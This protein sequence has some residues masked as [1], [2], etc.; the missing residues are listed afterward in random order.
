MMQYL[1]SRAGRAIVMRLAQE[2]T[3]CAFDFDGTL[4]PIVEHPAEAAMRAQ[5]RTLLDGL[6]ALYPCVILSGR[7]RADLLG[8]LDGV[9]VAGVI[10]NHG[11]ETEATALRQPRRVE[12]WKATLERELGAVPGVW[13]EDKILSLAVHYR[14]AAQKTEA[15]RRILA[16]VRDLEHV[17]VV[18]GKQ[19]VNLVVARAPD[20]GT[21]LATERDR[22]GCDWVLYVGDD[23]TDEHAFALEGNVVPV[24]IGRSRRSHARYW[25]R[26]QSEIDK[27]LELLMGL[28]GA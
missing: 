22:L 7:S 13:V 3:L 23:E 24:R 28:R 19:V 11:A 15:R 16:A 25:L 4:S 26:T 8:R 5:T 17:R 14:Q 21:A 27:L 10:G 1:L 9:K 20:K 18:A 12:Q 2:R 6:A